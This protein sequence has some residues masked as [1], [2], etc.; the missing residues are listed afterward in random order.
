MLGG[1]GGGG[2]WWVVGYLKVSRVSQPGG[3][4]WSPSQLQ[5]VEMIDDEV[6][7][8]LHPTGSPHWGWRWRGGGGGWLLTEG[9]TWLSLGFVFPTSH[10]GQ[11]WA[12]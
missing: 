4:T 6:V 1:G 9:Q 2:G 12:D 3:S 10:L 8:G 7:S 11:H 5:L